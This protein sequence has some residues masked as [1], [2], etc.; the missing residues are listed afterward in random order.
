VFSDT[1][2]V[3]VVGSV[4]SSNAGKDIALCNVRSVSLNGNIPSVGSW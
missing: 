1:T 2:I 4:T 3:T